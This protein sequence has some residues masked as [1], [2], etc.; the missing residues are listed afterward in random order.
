[1]PMT[2]MRRAFLLT[3]LL[4]PAYALG[5]PAPSIVV[6]NGRIFTADAEGPWAEALAISGEEI[7]SVGSNDDVLRL[8]GD[9]T[10]VIDAAGRL[11]IPGLNDA[12]VH[13]G[14]W[15]ET[16]SLELGE[17]PMPDPSWVDVLAAVSSAAADASEGMQLHGTIGSAVLD[18]PAA[19]RQALDAVAGGHPVFLWG[20]TGHGMVFN[21]PA[22]ELV[23]FTLDTPDMPGGMFRRDN[24][25]LT[26][27]V[28]EYGGVA[29][30]RRLAEDEGHDAT[31]AAY[32]RLSDRALRYGMTTV[33][34]MSTGA[35]LPNALSGLRDASTPLRW[36]IYHW[37]MPAEDVSEGWAEPPSGATGIPRVSVAGVKW[38]LDGTPVERGAAMRRP[39]AD[40]PEWTGVLNFSPAD[41]RRILE[42]ALARGEQ[43]AFHVSG[44]SAVALLLR[45]MA[46]IAPADRWRGLRV[47]LEHGDGLAPDLFPLAADLGVVHIQNPLH[48]ALP[49]VMGARMGER[50][51]GYQLLRSVG[52]AGIALALGSDA[53]GSGFNPFLNMMLAVAH[54]T[55]P[56]EGLTPEGALA[57][58][59][60]GAAHAERAESRKG[61]LRAGMQADVAILSQ[62]ILSIPPDQWPATESVLTIVGG[63]VAYEAGD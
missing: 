15:P 1:M 46:D 59:T 20:W 52:D 63:E 25:V 55:H 2:S 42:A 16:I 12:H 58:Y 62:D 6:H 27:R 28:D 44:D 10:R 3:A 49:A 29:A 21:T 31:V 41:I 40:R 39:Y 57:A 4:A 51:A 61:M 14:A 7:V 5:Q 37:P 19:T 33:Q 18:D 50:L 36:S 24:G 23:G 34:L 22:L 53:G 38:M 47:R 13:A 30:A 8:V 9:G 17:G 48:L 32:R 60:R 43:P 26:G 45:T 11:V 54:P 35:S 56:D